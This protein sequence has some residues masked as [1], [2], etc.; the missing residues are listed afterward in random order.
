[1]EAG[2]AKLDGESIDDADA[3]AAAVWLAALRA[4]LLA[5]PLPP[6]SF[7]ARL[8]AA[9]PFPLSLCSSGELKSSLC[10]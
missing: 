9:P 7:S 6:R 8:T 4:R 1:M 3:S 5:P 2:D 10:T